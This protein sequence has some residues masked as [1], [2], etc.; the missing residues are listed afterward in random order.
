MKKENSSSTRRCV[1]FAV[2]LAVGIMSVAS[3]ISVALIDESVRK[4][5]A[6]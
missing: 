6:N 5:E 1:S 2:L 4:G 3:C